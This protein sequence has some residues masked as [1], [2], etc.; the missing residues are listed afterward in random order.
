MVE[1]YSSKLV[2][3]GFLSFVEVTYPHIVSQFLDVLEE[4]QELQDPPYSRGVLFVEIY[5]GYRHRKWINLR[6]L[7]DV[8]FYAFTEMVRRDLFY[9]D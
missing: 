5:R 6:I 8:A 4:M 1:E 9:V 2:E 3:K 7:R